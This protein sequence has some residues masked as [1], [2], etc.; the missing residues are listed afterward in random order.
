MGLFKC[1]INDIKWG[2]TEGGHAA[3]ILDGRSENEKEIV[4]GYIGDYKKVSQAEAYDNNGDNKTKDFFIA[5]AYKA[6]SDYNSESAE[7]QFKGVLEGVR[8]YIT[9][10]GRSERQKA[11]TS[12]WIKIADYKKTLDKRIPLWVY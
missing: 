5:L 6:E 12:L 7:K 11:I 8:T 3:H 4:P 9:S 10:S 1:D 2:V